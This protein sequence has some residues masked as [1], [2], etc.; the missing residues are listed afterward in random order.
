MLFRSCGYAAL[1]ALL[2]LS[3]TPCRTAVCVLADKEE[4]GSVGVSGMQSAFFETFVGD[5]CATQKVP[6]RVCLEKSFCLSTDVTSAFDPNFPDVYE[7]NN[8][9]RVNHGV[10]LCKYTGSRG[11]G[12][13]SDAG[14][15]LFFSYTSGKLGSKAA[16][17]SVDRQKDFSRHTRRGTF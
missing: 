12:G 4:I 9:A 6:L 15:E 3:G 13:A 17:T 16:V 11:K 7:K 1:K 14:A 10:G 5:L 2:D 8:A